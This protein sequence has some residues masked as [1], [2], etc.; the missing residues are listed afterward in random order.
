MGKYEPRLEPASIDTPI[1]AGQI[2]TASSDDDGDKNTGMDTLEFNAPADTWS[3]IFSRA[4]RTAGEPETTGDTQPLPALPDS[5]SSADADDLTYWASDLNES[6]A[7]ESGQPDKDTEAD[8]VVDADD[9]APELDANAAF[10]QPSSDDREYDGRATRGTERNEG[11][12][13]AESLHHD[14]TADAADNDASENADAGSGSPEILGAEAEP[15]SFRQ[16]GT[17]E[18][19]SDEPDDERRAESQDSDSPANQFN[20]EDF[21]EEK[22][23]VQ[24]I[25][26]TDESEPDSAGLIQT[27]AAAAGEEMAPW[28]PDAFQP[29]PKQNSHTSLWLVGSFLVAA[30]LV[31]QLLHHNRDA[32]AGSTAW[33]TSVRSIYHR[34]GIELFPNWSLDDYE[35]RGSEAIAGESGPDIMDIRA[36]IAAIG[37]QPTGLPHIRVTLRDRWSNPVAAKILSPAEYA[38]QDSLPTN[39]LLQPSETLAAHVSIIDPGSGAQGFELE[40]CLPRRHTGLE[41]T[42]RPFD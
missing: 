18:E 32:L 23:D 40:L 35:I 9:W 41:C 12:Y 3:N 20:E 6:L 28:Q 19:A 24:H 22:Y 27:F 36:Q 38:L 16:D 39:E 7:A 15:Q 37:S 10:A 42:G 14:V 11:T 25:I 29:V 8:A 17:S 34:L 2:E 31:L 26:L 21:D 1:D 30:T 33:G 13:A 4:A 5:Q